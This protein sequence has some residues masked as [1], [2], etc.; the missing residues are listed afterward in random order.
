MIDSLLKRGYKPSARE[1]RIIFSPRTGSEM[2]K[3]TL[4]RTPIHRYSELCRLAEKHGSDRMLAH[5]FKEANSHIVLLQDPRDM[6][7]GHWISISRNL[8]KK[9]I[10]FFSTY[11]RKPDVEK[12]DWMSDDDLQE[13]GQTIN[14]F[15]DGLRD[16]QKHG[17]EIHYND[18]P[19]QKEGDKTATCGIYTVAFLRSGLNPEE[20]ER[21]TVRIMKQKRSPAVVYYDQYF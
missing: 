5:L 15:N 18:F 12:I 2:E 11:G 8:P 13:S 4:N 7:S 14:I 9:E 6:N 16:L 1:H 21:E 17:W 19:Y 10:Y 20:F 3:A